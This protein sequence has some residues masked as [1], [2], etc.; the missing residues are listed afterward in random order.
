MLREVLCTDLVPPRPLHETIVREKSCADVMGL[1]V[2]FRDSLMQVCC[3]VCF[4]FV[5][6]RRE[7]PSD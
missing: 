1:S 7:D 2:F 5:S 6:G 3:V 4:C